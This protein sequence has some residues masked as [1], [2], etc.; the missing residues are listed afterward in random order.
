MSLQLTMTITE[1]EDDAAARQ[2]DERNKGIIFANCNFNLN[3]KSEI[4]NI[5]NAKDIDIIML[6]C[7]VIKF[8]DNNS[9]ASGSL[10]QYYKDEPSVRL[11]DS[12][13]YKSKTKTTA[14]GN[15][16]D[17]EIIVPLK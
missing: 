9:K 17:T 8:S 1:A 13:S 3:Y 5:D 11:I 7:N 4:N 6:M 15:T 12:K 16:I 14:N 10:W 2:A